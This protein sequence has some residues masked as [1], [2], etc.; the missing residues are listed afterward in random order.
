MIAGKRRVLV[1]LVSGA[2]LALTGC[3]SSTEETVTPATPSVAPDVPVGFEPCTDIPQ[4]VLGSEGL[5]SPSPN[6]SS[7]GGIKWNGCMWVQ[8]DGYGASIQTTNI[9]LQMVKDKHFPEETEFTVGDRRAISTRQLEEH[10]EA[11]CIV[12]VEMKGGSLEISLTNPPS[13][14]KTGHLDTC[15][16]ARNLANKVAPTIPAN[17]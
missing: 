13:R 7:S 16:L 10:A 9:T 5:R 1:A 14:R 8:T 4:E 12:N 2:V 11:S 6:D 15:E 3:E 17:A